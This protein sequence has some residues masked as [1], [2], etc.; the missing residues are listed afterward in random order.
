MQLFGFYW[1]W[2][3][4]TVLITSFSMVAKCMNLPLRNTLTQYDRMKTFRFV[5]KRKFIIAIEFVNTMTRRSWRHPTLFKYSI[6]LYWI[7]LSQHS[8]WTTCC[9][10]K[11]Y[12]SNRIYLK[13]IRTIQTN[14]AF[15]FKMWSNYLQSVTSRY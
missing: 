8:S 14:N 10:M 13:Y 9:E 12:R 11:L 15:S 2:H 7:W 3:F 6:T 1:I 5:Y 4:C